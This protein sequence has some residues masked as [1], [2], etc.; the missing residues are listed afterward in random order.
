MIIKIGNQII[1][2]LSQYRVCEP[3][4]S[5]KP[6]LILVNIE[7]LLKMKWHPMVSVLNSRVKE[8]GR[9]DI[10]TY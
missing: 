2:I 4:L 3:P 5:S 1:N 7:A 10:E 9:L 8:N 6:Y